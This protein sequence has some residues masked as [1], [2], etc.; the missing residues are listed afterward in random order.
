MRDDCAAVLVDGNAD[1][2]VEHGLGSVDADLVEVAAD[3]LGGAHVVGNDPGGLVAQVNRRSAEQAAA[4]V[5]MVVAGN[6]KGDGPLVGQGG[7]E[8]LEGCVGT[9]LGRCV[10][11]IDGF[12]L[13]VGVGGG[14]ALVVVDFRT[15]AGV[16][17]AEPVPL[18]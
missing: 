16:V 5:Q 15:G 6:G 7:V 3:E 13:P 10:G 14:A 12:E 9:G 1:I 18:R 2:V 11:C 8:V 4:G 17:G